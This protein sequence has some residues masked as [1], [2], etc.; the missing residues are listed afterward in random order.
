MGFSYRYQ[1]CT[2]TETFLVNTIEEHGSYVFFKDGN[3]CILFHKIE[4]DEAGLYPDAVLEGDGKKVSLIEVS[5]QFRS[6]GEAFAAMDENDRMMEKAVAE[7]E[8]IGYKTDTDP[9]D[10]Q[11]G[12]PKII[13]YDYLFN[14]F[15]AD[16][17]G[18]NMVT[19][20]YISVAFHLWKD[21]REAR[22]TSDEPYIEVIRESR[23]V[24]GGIPER[25]Y[26]C[27]LIK[28]SFDRE[29]LY[30]ITVN[31]S[32]RDFMVMVWGLDTI[33]YEVVDRG[34]DFR[35]SEYVSY[36]A[37]IP[38]EMWQAFVSG[39]LDEFDIWD[40]QNAQCPSFGW[41]IRE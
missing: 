6:S 4:T 28:V 39:H 2:E 25:L 9:G 35:E 22:I 8:Q 17:F 11:K 19:G 37:P 29:H 18:G 20:A 3:D 30:R 31:E 5:R 10:T 24:P 7:L 15:G 32:L 34:L 13:S 40:N 12:V 36:P 16:K 14:Y 33:T 41:I 26:L 23:L 1:I 38:E 27:N 21:G